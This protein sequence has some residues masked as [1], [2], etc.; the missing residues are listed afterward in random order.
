MVAIIH[1][2]RHQKIRVAATLGNHKAEEATKLATEGSIWDQWLKTKFGSPTWDTACYISLSLWRSNKEYKWAQHEGAHKGPNGA[3]NLPDEWIIVSHNLASAY[4]KDHHST[5][6][7][8]KTAIIV[9]HYYYTSKLT[10]VST[11]ISQKYQTC[12]RTEPVSSPKP[13]PCVQH[14]GLSLFED[15]QIDFMEIKTCRGYKYLLVL[16]CTYS[17]WPETHFTRT[18]KATEVYRVLLRKII[19]R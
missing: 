18:E 2:K 4:V 10:P 7:G 11:S 3:W 13:P 15:L 16:V 5:T 9:S 6:H 17:D 14:A 12:V 19:P 8:G 1:C